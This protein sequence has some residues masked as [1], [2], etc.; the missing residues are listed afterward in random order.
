[1]GRDSIRTLA[2]SPDGT[3]LAIGGYSEFKVW[4][5][6]TGN[7]LYSLPG[8]EKSIYS[9]TFSPVDKETMLLAVEGN[10]G[11]I[12]VWDA[13]SGTLVHIIQTPSSYVGVFTFS[14]D[15]K[16][17]AVTTSEPSTEPDTPDTPIVQIWQ[18]TDGTLLRTLKADMDGSSLDFSPDTQY[19]VSYVPNGVIRRWDSETGNLIDTLSGFGPPGWPP[20]PATPLF[21]Y[22]SDDKMFILNPFN[23]LIELWALETGQIIKTLEGHQSQVTNLVLSDDGRTLVSAELW[24]TTVRIWDPVTGQNLGVYK[25]YFDTGYSKQLAI[26]PD[27]QLMVIGNS[28]A[29]RLEVYDSADLG[30]WVYQLT[31]EKYRSYDPVFSPDGQNLAWFPEARTVAVS[32][33]E[34]GELLH[35]WETTADYGNGLAFAPDSQVLAVGTQDGIQLWDS[36]TGEPINTLNGE[37]DN[38]VVSL[39]YSPDGRLLAAGI[40]YPQLDFVGS[41]TSTIELWDVEKG[42]L[43]Q[44]IEGYQASIIHVEFSPDGALLATA[45]SDGT[46]RL[47]GVPP[48]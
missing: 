19:L 36:T 46:M 40:E 32:K 15:S 7:L 1:M 18:V 35:T 33:A 14:S 23:N 12:W 9:L 31:K 41:L 22:L 6:R 2:I 42:L 44:A 8:F 43:L 34:T 47:W 21:A 4:D 38:I 45:S 17:L 39:A 13:R 29:T 24:D 10:E 26:S 28:R 48:E 30:D 27:G 3:L 5:V 16:L 20:L 25:V 11:Q 37:I